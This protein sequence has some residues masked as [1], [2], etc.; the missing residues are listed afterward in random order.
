MSKKQKKRMSR[1]KRLMRSGILLVLLIAIISGVCLFAPFF[2]ITKIKVEGNAQVLTEEILD[3]APIVVGTN[4]FKLNKRTVKKSLTSLAYLDKIKVK[5]SLPS[6]VRIKVTESYA[7]LLF[8]YASGYVVTDEAGKVLEE[9][10]DCTGWELPQ[11]IGV[12]IEQVKISEKITVQDRVKFDIILDCIQYFKE[13]GHLENMS[14]MD[15]SDIT[16]IWITYKEGFRVNFAKFENMDYKLKMLDAVLP[17][18][19]RSEGTYIDLTT[20]SKVFTGKKE[21]TPEPTAEAVEGEETN[22]EETG[23]EVENNDS[24]E[25]IDAEATEKDEL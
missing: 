24:G 6:T 19:D 7:H 8:P 22:Q 17:Q 16:N 11:V 1:A 14:V 3:R 9:I 18:V 10:S 15:F 5:R 21:P 2:N 25:E 20:P 4:I 12:E 23:A 13:H